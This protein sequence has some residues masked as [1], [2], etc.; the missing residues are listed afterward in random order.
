MRCDPRWPTVR[1]GSS[2][3][4]RT[5]ASSCDCDRAINP[6]N[7]KVYKSVLPQQERKDV[8]S[9][10][11]IYTQQR[12]PTHRS[13]QPESVTKLVLDLR[14][15]L[16]LGAARTFYEDD[17]TQTTEGVRLFFLTRHVVLGC[18]APRIHAQRGLVR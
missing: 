8:R 4:D 16:A 5:L 11:D 14:L 2:G 18:W 3:G 1:R 13:M 7:N 9:T 10:G 12:Q 15:A 6:L 17:S